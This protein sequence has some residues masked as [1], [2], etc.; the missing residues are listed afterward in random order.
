MKKQSLVLLCILAIN[1]IVISESVNAGNELDKA[2]KKI[3]IVWNGTTKE[4]RKR[5]L[6]EQREWLKKREIDCKAEPN[7]EGC[8]VNMTIARTE[9]LKQ[10]TTE[11]TEQ[12]N[13]TDS[14]VSLHHKSVEQDADAQNKLGDAYYS[15]QGVAQD[16][17]QA[18][19]WY[20]K[21]A[22]QGLAS[23]QANLGVMYENGNGVAQDYAQ[24][25]SW[26][27]KAAEQGDAN[28]QYNLGDAYFSG[29]AV[30]ASYDDAMSWF[31]KAAAQGN[32]EA[33]SILKEQEKN[34]ATPVVKP[35]K[36]LVEPN[37][38][39]TKNTEE[40]SHEILTVTVILYFIFFLYLIFLYLK[41]TAEELKG[42]GKFILYLFL[43]VVICSLLSL[44]I[45]LIS[46][47]PIAAIIL[48]FFWLFYRYKKPDFAFKIFNKTKELNAKISY[49]AIVISIILM[50]MLYINIEFTIVMLIV[51]FSFKGIIKINL[52]SAN[53]KIEVINRENNRKRLI[54][55]AIDEIINEHIKALS[56]EFS[57]LTRKDAYGNIIYDKWLKELDYFI[58]NVLCKNP[59]IWQYIKHSNSDVLFEI[60]QKITEVVYEYNKNNKNQDNIDVANLS[61]ND[62]EHYCANILSQNGWEARVTKASGDQGIDVIAT[63]GNIKAVFQCKKYSNP[64]GNGAVQEIVAGKQFEQ[65]NIAAVVSNIGY[66]ASAKQLAQSTGT[67][68]L[69]YSELA[70]FHNKIGL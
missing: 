36:L 14:I 10:K 2:N 1:G 31:R 13:D 37:K 16:Y 34:N 26:Y 53:Q 30:V 45:L 21:A 12:K 61:P 22:E 33:Q 8:M 47:S 62:F 17:D 54:N 6:S 38:N 70:D 19:S 20:S 58:E 24:A 64:V 41:R 42:L 60:K 63:Y 46:Y 69:H 40:K 59:K 39:E 44:F 15:G 51:Y 9:E 49:K 7:P 67:Y 23:A 35:N 32:T 48:I 3:N 68:L 27:R 43:F 66:T 56:L 25:I 18:L 28:A 55:Y 29:K 5:I 11:I 4:I 65:A 57:K 50:T 52:E